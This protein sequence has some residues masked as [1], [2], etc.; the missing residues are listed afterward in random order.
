MGVFNMEPSDSS[1]EEFLESNNL[2]N[3]IKSNS[4]L[5]GKDPCIEIIL[6]NKR[7]SFKFTSLYETGISD[8]HHMIYTILKAKVVQ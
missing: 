3:L 1:Q 4:C 8:H 6:T 5:K 7:Y 2:T